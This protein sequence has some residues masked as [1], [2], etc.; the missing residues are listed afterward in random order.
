MAAETGE[1]SAAAM[2]SVLNVK[3]AREVLQLCGVGG[4]DF[5]LPID[6]GAGET[7]KVGLDARGPDLKMHVVGVGLAVPG[8][9]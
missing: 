3:R 5:A 8:R 6:A 1:K 9:S 7:L 4:H 2:G